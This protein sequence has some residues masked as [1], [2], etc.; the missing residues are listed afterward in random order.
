MR[1]WRLRPEPVTSQDWQLQ[2]SVAPAVA[3]LGAA[4]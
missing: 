2:R 3:E 1:E 4:T